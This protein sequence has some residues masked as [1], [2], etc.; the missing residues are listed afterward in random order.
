MALDAVGE[1]FRVLGLVAL[2]WAGYLLAQC[3]CNTLLKCKDHFYQF[4]AALVM[5]H[6]VVILDHWRTPKKIT[7]K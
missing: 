7:G 5:A 4:S 1:G 2:I 6:G 3:P